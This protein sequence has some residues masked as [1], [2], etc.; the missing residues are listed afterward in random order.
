V[1]AVYGADAD[2]MTDLPAERTPLGRVA[3]PEDIAA[4]LLFLAS[5]DAWHITATELV[6]DGGS[7]A[8]II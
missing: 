6:I 5:A 3:E 4:A 7:S 2:H 1:E 8:R